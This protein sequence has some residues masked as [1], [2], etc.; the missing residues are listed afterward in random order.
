MLEGTLHQ[1]ERSQPS[2]K[3]LRSTRRWQA[4]AA[5]RESTPMPALALWNKFWRLQK[6]RFV[7][8]VGRVS[9]SCRG[10]LKIDSDFQALG[11]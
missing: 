8:L 5:H 1:L 3:L 4:K 6:T 9:L 2:R 10:V 7:G 11:I